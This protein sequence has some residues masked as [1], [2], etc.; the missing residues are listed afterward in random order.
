[1]NIIFF[2]KTYRTEFWPFSGLEI[3]SLL[4]GSEWLINWLIDWMVMTLK[5]L[6]FFSLTLLVT[7][8]RP[9]LIEVWRNEKRLS[10]PFG[11]LDCL[12]S[13]RSAYRYSDIFIW[14]SEVITG[15]LEK[16][17]IRTEPR[18][19]TLYLFRGFAPVR[20]YLI[21]RKQHWSFNSR[22]WNIHWV[23]VHVH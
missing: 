6:F 12:L 9:F 1:M 19:Q 14:E 21:C 22:Q 10:Q 20:T 15:L 5:C 18:V 4:W 17:R 3:K 2:K 23:K 13:G 16:S 7:H 11:Q 8:Q